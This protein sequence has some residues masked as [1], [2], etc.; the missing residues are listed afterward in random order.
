MAEQGKTDAAIPLMERA[1]KIRE[2]VLGPDHMEV[3]I[4]LALLAASYLE[5]GDTARAEALFRRALRIIENTFGPDHPKVCLPLISLAQLY[6]EKGD[7]A[8]AEAV[9]RR[10]LK[11]LETAH[12]PDNFHVGT[13]LNNLAQMYIKKGEY[14]RAKPLAER[15]LTIF[16]KALGADHHDVATPLFKLSTTYAAQGDVGR[17]VRFLTRANDIYEHALAPVIATG[18][19]KDKQVLS[20]HYAGS[21]DY[22]VTFNV[23]WAPQSPEATRIALTLVLRR[24]GRA[25]DTM[26][27]QI[28]ALRQ[29]VDTQSSALLDRWKAVNSQLSTL[30]LA[31]PGRG[32]LGATKGR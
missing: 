11:I 28:S 8:R 1:A 5:V 4:T 18:S 24:K 22:T 27:D 21:L 25:L 3:A 29:R 13:V 6:K 7:Y 26:A 31:G 30:T 16:E 23:H 9:Y 19:E 12:G 32:G 10:L 15:A 20:R 17:A 2:Q 14:A